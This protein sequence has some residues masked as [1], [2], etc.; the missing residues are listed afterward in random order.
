M[1]KISLSDIADTENVSVYYLSHF[2][3]K[4]LGI[5]FREYVNKLRLNKAATL[6]LT[7]NK[8]KIDICM[9]SG[10]TDYRYVVKAFSKQYK[11]TPTEFRR[12]YKND[13]SFMDSKENFETDQYLIMDSNSSYIR[14]QEY[15]DSKK[16]V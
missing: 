6:L 15:I 3:K 14:F 12:K 2:I 9:E 8:K 10:F 1:Y 11:C 16:L 4:H 13:A 5:S 7:T